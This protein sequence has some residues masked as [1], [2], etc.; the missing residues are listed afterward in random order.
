V[1]SLWILFQ[2]A[3]DRVVC[4]RC[5]R[6][7]GA[8]EHPFYGALHIADEVVEVDVDDLRRR[9]KVPVSD[10]GAKEVLGAG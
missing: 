1:F 9:E 2:E 10:A 3:I 6:V 7:P 5:I 4:R 8:L